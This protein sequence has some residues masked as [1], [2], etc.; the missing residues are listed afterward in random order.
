[1]IVARRI[2]L[3]FSVAV[4]SVG[5]SPAVPAVAAPKACPVPAS[6]A[7]SSYE[8]VHTYRSDC[9]TDQNYD[10]RFPDVTVST[11]VDGRNRL[12][13]TTS[14]ALAGA[15]GSLTV[16]DKE[17]IASGG[18]G[19]AFQYAFHMW[20]AGE[21]PSE[22]WNPT[23]AG[24]RIDSDGQSPPF[25]AK[26]STSA[27]YEMRGSKSSV[28]TAGRPAMYM[29]RADPTPGYD[30]CRTTDHQPDRAPFNQGLS[31]F[32]LRTGVHLGADN[33]VP[34]LQNVIRLTA[35]LTSEEGPYEQFDGLLIA[36]LQRDFT[37]VHSF[38]GGRLVPQAGTLASKDPLVRCTTDG[39]YCFGMYVRPAA[40]AA[41]AYYYAMTRP[42]TPYNGMTGET[43][44]QVTSQT[45]NVGKGTTVDYETYAVV[46][47]RDRVADTL[48]TLT[49]TVK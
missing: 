28:S 42:P 14:T 44:V 27:L 21:H 45:A 19:A 13:V 18:Y 7:P 2:L 34:G 6:T 38:S 31:P 16:N 24:A 36:Y 49:Q 29:T 11:P 39:S 37:T 9:A 8:A 22:C 10:R 47:N 17:F 4:L 43:T 46:G 25:H 41:G 48:R 12:A 33:G 15:I 1:V 26:A 23:Q 20:R 35:G 3:A 5:V 32:W 30:G 40:L